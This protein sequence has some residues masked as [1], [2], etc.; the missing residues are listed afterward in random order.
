MPTTR[1]RRLRPLTLFKDKGIQALVMDSPLDAPFIS[2][3]ESKHE[4]VRFARVDAELPD[5]LM[6]EGTVD[7]SDQTALEAGLRPGGRAG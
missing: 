6:G 4:G 1:R 2:M 3:I 5:V 7:L